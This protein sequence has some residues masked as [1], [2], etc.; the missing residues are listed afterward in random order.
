MTT[1]DLTL[2]LTRALIALAVVYAGLFAIVTI[3][4]LQT[5]ERF[6][7]FMKRMPMLLVWGV[8]PGTRLWLWARRGT[9]RVGDR[10]PD[11]SLRSLRDR[12]TRVSLSSYR[13]HRPVVLVFGSYT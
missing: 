13:G 6:G 5:P 3:A 1:I 8:V 9:L 2:W 4:M 7:G 11:F 12:S 10:A